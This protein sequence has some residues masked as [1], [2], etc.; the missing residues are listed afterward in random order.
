MVTAHYGYS[1][2]DNEKA[3]HLFLLDSQD[4]TCVA[5]GDNEKALHLFLLDSQDST[6]V[7]W[8]DRKGK[9]QHQPL[10]SPAN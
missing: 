10:Y 1:M 7:A 9:E 5:W 6:C 3:L 2:G 4:S 8:G